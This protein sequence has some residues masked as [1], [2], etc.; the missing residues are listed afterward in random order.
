MNWSQPM[1]VWRSDSAAAR[2]GGEAERG[3]PL[4]EDGEVISAAVHLEEGRPHAMHMSE[5][6]FPRYAGMS[7]QTPPARRLL[8]M[9][10]SASIVSTNS[11]SLAPFQP[12]PVRTSLAKLSA[13]RRKP[14]AA[15]H[16]LGIEGDGVG[17]AAL[18]AQRQRAGGG[19]VAVAGLDHALL[20]DDDGVAVEAGRQAGGDLADDAGGE[21]QRGRH[22]L[23]DA[24][25][26]EAAGGEDAGRALAGDDADE[27]GGVGAGDISAPPPR[28][29]SRRMLLGLATGSPSGV[30]MPKPKLE[31]MTWT[32]PSSPAARISRMRSV[33]GWDM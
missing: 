10:S 8:A 25:L 15:R 11:A 27:A 4:V 2:A 9:A 21:F 18:D 19:V 14:V 7:I 1:P 29:G 5:A 13:S 17:H 3:R 23:V 22:G 30:A 28:S 33:C 26:G 31:V 6:S 12:L 32:R 16:F 24:G 20:A